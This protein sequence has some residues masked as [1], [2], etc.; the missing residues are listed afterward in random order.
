MYIRFECYS[1]AAIQRRM[2]VDISYLPPNNSC[3][4]LLRTLKLG[5]TRALRMPSPHVCHSEDLLFHTMTTLAKRVL[6]LLDVQ[7]ANLADPPKGVPAAAL[8]R[9]NISSVLTIARSAKP[10]P[11]IIHVRNCGDQG[12]ADEAHAP[13]WQLLLSPLPHEPVVD[14]LKNNAFAGTKLA[15]MI[16]PDAE[17]VVVGLGS[18]FSVRASE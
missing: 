4:E 2:P 10:P 7:V 12:D 1:P 9:N 14:K 8:L 16:A 17:I 15:E 3:L 5:H 13:G 6:L 11:L 18:D